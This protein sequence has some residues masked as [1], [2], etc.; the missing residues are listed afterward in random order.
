MRIRL[1]VPEAVLA[2]VT[3]HD[4]TDLYRN[5]HGAKPMKVTL[6]S[7]SNIHDLQGMPV[8]EWRGTS[9]E[10]HPVIAMIPGFFVKLPDGMPTPVEPPARDVLPLR[11]HTTLRQPHQN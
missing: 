10:G 6:E 11:T 3:P 8:R 7:T 1:L 4:I 5:S 2:V 9:E